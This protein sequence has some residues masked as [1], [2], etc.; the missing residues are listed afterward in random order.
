MAS[1]GNK[2]VRRAQALSDLSRLSALLAGKFSL[3]LPD[4]PVTSKDKELAE[5]QR[6]ETINQMLEHVLQ[7]DDANKPF[8]ASLLEDLTKA[9]LFD[10]AAEMQVEVNKSATKA[11]I[12]AAIEQHGANK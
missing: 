10:K 8:S 3:E 12:I 7:V 5:I 2:I 1:K 4:A 11:E 6:I 9:E